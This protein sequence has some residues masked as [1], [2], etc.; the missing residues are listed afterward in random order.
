MRTRISV[1]TIDD[2]K[3]IEGVAFKWQRRGHLISRKLGRSFIKQ[4]VNCCRVRFQ[5]GA[6]ETLTSAAAETNRR[7]KAATGAAV[8]ACTGRSLPPSCACPKAGGGP[9]PFA[10]TPEPRKFRSETPRRGQKVAVS[11]EKRLL[12]Q[13][14]DKHTSRQLTYFL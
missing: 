10:T 9:L 7:R 4:E 1:T 13:G 6:H 5:N 12:N 3:T 2:D 11:V 14:D 8:Q